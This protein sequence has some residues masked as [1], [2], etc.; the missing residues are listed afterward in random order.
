M[1]QRIRFFFGSAALLFLLSAQSQA[2]ISYLNS[3]DNWAHSCQALTKKPNKH[4]HHHKRLHQN[5]IDAC[6]SWAKSPP[7]SESAARDFLRLHFIKTYK[8]NEKTL[9]TGYYAPIIHACWIRQPQCSAP[10]YGL[11]AKP[12]RHL[13]R[14]ELNQLN[15]IRLP[16]LAWVDPIERYFLQIQGSGVLHF[17]SG[18]SVH[19]GYAGKNNQ[20]YTSIGRYL[21]QQKRIKKSELNLKGIQAYLRAHPSQRQA[22]FEKNKSFVFFKAKKNASVIG[23]LGV[24]LAGRLSAAVDNRFIPLGSLIEVKTTDPFKHQHW[25]MLL[26]AQDTGGAIR[27][28]H[29]IDVYMGKGEKAKKWAGNMHQ[30]GQL[31]YYIPIP[32][33]GAILPK[34]ITKELIRPVRIHS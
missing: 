2:A 6:A 1:W 22:V 34:S 15:P 14:L 10:V 5:W 19:L 33:G 30:Q 3:L 25:E 23:K 9:I 31:I 13:S 8:I 21:N 18:E 26:T 20:P 16:V 4:W 32:H 28:A 17:N 12:Y 27:G 24:P 11:P 29:H 7:K